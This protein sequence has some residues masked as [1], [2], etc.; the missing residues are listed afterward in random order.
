MSVGPPMRVVPV[1][2][3]AT[4]FEPMLMVVPCMVML[5]IGISQYSEAAGRSM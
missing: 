4:L 5:A 1:S 2:I 3:A